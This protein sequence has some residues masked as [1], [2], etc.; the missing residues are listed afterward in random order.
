MDCG[1]ASS[2]IAATVE[3]QRVKPGA[4]PVL[5]TTGVVTPM[6]AAEVGQRGWKIVHAKP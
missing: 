1:S 3:I 2:F 4:V 6:A 5:A